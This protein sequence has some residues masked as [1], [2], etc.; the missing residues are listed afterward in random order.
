MRK[1]I[2]AGVLSLGVLGVLCVPPAR[3]VD[4]DAINRAIE[5][6]V[7]H[8]RSIQRADGTWTHPDLGATALNGLALLECGAEGDDRSVAAAAAVVRERSIA[9]THTYSLSLA[10][11]F[12]DRLGDPADVPLIESMAVRLLGGQMATG[13]WSYKCPP[14]SAAEVE[15]LT[16]QVRQRNELVARRDPPAPGGKRAVKDLPPEIQEQLVLVQ[17]AGPWQGEALGAAGD[18]SDNSNTQFAT[19]ALWVAR[20]HGIPVDNALGRIEARFRASQEEDGGWGY[21]S[22]LTA[23]GA[24]LPR[25][26]R[27]PMAVPGGMAPP[28]VSTATM[29]CSGILG[30]TVVHGAVADLARDANS[31]VKPRDIDKDKDLARALA[32][33]STAVDHPAGDRKDAE[34][35]RAAGK[36][37]YFLWSLERVCVALDLQL[38]DKKDWY[39][40]GA[41]ILLANQQ[42]DGSW[43]GEY[44]TCGADTAFALLFLKKANLTRDLTAGIRGKLKDPAEAMLK[45][46]GVGGAGLKKGPARL[47]PAIE[48]KNEQKE[49]E[50]GKS[51][52][53]EPER[54]RPSDTPSARLAEELVKAPAAEQGALLQKLQDTKGVENTEALA[55]AIPRLEGAV[56]QKAR[57]ALAARL[58]RLKA[59]S[60]I[61]YLED[62]EPEI[63]RA[64]AVACAAKKL[65][66]AV[67]RLIPRLRDREEMVAKAA[68]AALKDLS[69]QDL[70]PTPAEWEAWWKTQAKE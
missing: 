55:F 25:L 67:P 47:K 31:K 8:L 27:P 7:S 3:S 53:K 36:S 50:R 6:G 5:R 45:A 60:L 58:A 56:Q 28:G 17:R 2:L 35:P 18:M 33:L 22:G 10:I 65:R 52:P 54:T 21:N 16:R 32:A 1:A 15:R 19:I 4:S 14:I 42:G 49:P 48:G 24:R 30:L 62:D 59:E 34:I 68:H 23:T 40:W 11:L 70:G 61:K 69:G 57:E 20:R 51:E 12:L 43:R 37:Y 13:G 44:A 38:L 66:A 46:G 39:A 26:A 41:E 9:C 29:T 63:R 64:A